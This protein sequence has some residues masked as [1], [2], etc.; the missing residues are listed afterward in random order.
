MQSAVMQTIQQRERFQRNEKG[1]HSSLTQGDAERNTKFFGSIIEK[2]WRAGLA[3][4]R[5]R[6]AQEWSQLAQLEHSTQQPATDTSAISNT[7]ARDRRM[8]AVTQSAEQMTFRVIQVT[9]TGVLAEPYEDH[10]VASSMARIGGGGGVGS[11]LAPSGTVAF[12]RG[13]TGAAEGDRIERK[14]VPDGTHTY[15]DT[16]GASR[17]VRRWQ[18]I[19]SAIEQP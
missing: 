7:L 13:V 8:R 1:P 17:T 4:L 3:Q 2:D 16:S 18:T 15:L 14:V 12:V 5:A 11:Y 6:A 9:A 19:E 10:A